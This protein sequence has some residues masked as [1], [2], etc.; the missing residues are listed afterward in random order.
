MIRGVPSPLGSGNRWNSG[1]SFVYQRNGSY[2]VYKYTGGQSST[3]A[4]W[5][6]S[7]AINAGSAWNILRLVANGSTVDF[8]INQIH[9]GTLNNTQYTSGKVGLIMYGDGSSGDAFYADWATLTTNLSSTSVKDSSAIVVDDSLQ[10]PVDLTDVGDG[11]R[12]SVNYRPA[13]AAALKEE[14]PQIVPKN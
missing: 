1:Y 13:N 2:A 4:S 10:H 14:K 11:A 7:S 5:T 8:Y 3:L 12:M 9:I 6:S